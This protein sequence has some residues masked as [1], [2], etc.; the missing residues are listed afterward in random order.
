MNP[1]NMFYKKEIKKQRIKASTKDP[2]EVSELP[3]SGT[4]PE[5]SQV[6][7]KVTHYHT[8]QAATEHK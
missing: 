2:R 6:N 8:I 4:K 1:L 3:S 5:N 7:N